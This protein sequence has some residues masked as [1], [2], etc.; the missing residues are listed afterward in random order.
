M[1]SSTRLSSQ[2]PN[3]IRQLSDPLSCELFILVEDFLSERLQYHPVGSFYL[4]VGSWVCHRGIFDRNALLLAE[5]EEL[6]ACEV[7]S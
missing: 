1:Q 2:A 7:G 3:N 4:P 6:G 5:I